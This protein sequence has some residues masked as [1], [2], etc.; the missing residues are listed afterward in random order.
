M[1]QT[2]LDLIVKRGWQL[3][4]SEY[5]RLLAKEGWSRASSLPSIIEW[6]RYRSGVSPSNYIEEIRTGVWLAA[7]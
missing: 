1:R 2:V 4:L 3:W 5:E 7:A 6:E